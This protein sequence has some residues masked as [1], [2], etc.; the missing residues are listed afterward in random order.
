MSHLVSITWASYL[1]KQS[2]IPTMWYS[3][4]TG[5]FLRWIMSVGHMVFLDGWNMVQV[6]WQWDQKLL[7]EKNQDKGRALAF[8]AFIRKNIVMTSYVPLG[9]FCFLFLVIKRKTLWPRPHWY[10]LMLTTVTAINELIWPGWYYEDQWLPNPK[11]KMCY[12]HRILHQVF[13]CLSSECIL[14]TDQCW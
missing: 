12:F 1:A 13:E 11:T 10:Q 2:Q 5:K 6:Q 3:T 14:V 4:N 8:E 7:L 9:I